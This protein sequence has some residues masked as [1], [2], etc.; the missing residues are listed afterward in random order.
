[1]GILSAAG[2]PFP[3][4][5]C[6][7]SYHRSNTS[8]HFAQQRLLFRDSFIFP[9]ESWIVHS[10]SVSHLLSLAFFLSR[11]PPFP[12]FF[13]LGWGGY[14]QLDFI[15]F[16]QRRSTCSRA[17]GPWCVCRSED[18]VCA[19]RVL[20]QRT[21][22]VFERCVPLHLRLVSAADRDKWQ[23]SEMTCCLSILTG[24]AVWNDTHIWTHSHF[25]FNL[26]LSV[27]RQWHGL[28][29]ELLFWHEWK[30]I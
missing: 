24:W 8:A 9:R 4:P 25:S 29:I 12:F 26:L 16:C 10:L 7:R 5:G 17:V 11:S 15:Q 20:W 23:H 3:F 1:M 30:N 19:H 27:W 18:V 22:C 2:E 21:E 6:E 13:G 28:E 14:F